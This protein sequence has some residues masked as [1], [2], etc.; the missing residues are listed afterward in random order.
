VVTEGGNIDVDGVADDGQE[1]SREDRPSTCVVLGGVQG[2]CGDAQG[3][4]E[5]KAWLEGLAE[6][7]RLDVAKVID[8]AL[9]DYAKHEGYEP[10]APQR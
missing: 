8:R 1:E 9:I 10:E 4:P 6:H 3:D 7:C 2:G 5:G